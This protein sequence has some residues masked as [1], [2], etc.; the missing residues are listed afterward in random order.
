MGIYTEPTA[1]YQLAEI[2]IARIKGVNIHDPVMKEFVDNLD[3]I[4]A[5]AENSD[6]FVWRLKDDDNNATSF[7]PYD[8][9]QVIINISVCTSI[10]LL[11]N[12]VFNALHTDF[13]RRRKEWFR[14]FGKV[15]TAMWWI[16]EGSFPSMPEAIDKLD[17]IRKIGATKMCFDFKNRFPSPE[18][19]QTETEG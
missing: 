15:T 7:N 3:T 5:L 12:F 1:K 6:C 14:H 16:E 4:N 13:L 2:N 18:K 11:G 17:Q 9:E 8:D 10:K 19:W